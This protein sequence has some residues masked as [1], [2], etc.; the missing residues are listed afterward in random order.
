MRQAR[1]AYCWCVLCVAATPHALPLHTCM[2]NTGDHNHSCCVRSRVH[3]CGRSARITMST[4]AAGLTW[5]VAGVPLDAGHGLD[6]P[7][8]AGQQGQHAAYVAHD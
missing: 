7:Q 4:T 8:A 2:S 6:A 1:A 3:C 5:L